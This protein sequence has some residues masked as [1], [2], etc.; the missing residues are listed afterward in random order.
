MTESN[1][2]LDSESETLRYTGSRLQQPEAAEAKPVDDAGGMDIEMN[3]E[4]RDLR[5]NILAKAPLRLY[6]WVQRN[7]DRRT[8]RSDVGLGTSAK[9]DS[10]RI[11]FYS[12]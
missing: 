3:S 6:C 9:H 1:N 8:E 7:R 4:E 12:M 10:G 5:E 2:Q 11:L